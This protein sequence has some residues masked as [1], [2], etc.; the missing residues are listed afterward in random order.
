MNS[1]LTFAAY[2]KEET[3]FHHN[4]LLAFLNR[5]IRS[6]I[7][8]KHELLNYYHVGYIYVSP[9][10]LPQLVVLRGQV[11]LA[12][13]YFTLKIGGFQLMS[14]LP[15]ILLVHRTKEKKVF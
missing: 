8:V 2:M 12:Y 4:R 10:L 3:C 5:K 7:I 6:K 13:Y 15:I 14:S 9:L 1:L 11:I